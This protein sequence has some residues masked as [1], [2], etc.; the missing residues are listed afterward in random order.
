MK[1]ERKA[2]LLNFLRMQAKPLSIAEI[3]HASVIQELFG[4][5]QKTIQ[6]DIKELLSEGKVQSRDNHP[7]RFSAATPIEVTVTLTPS[8]IRELMKSASA[9]VKA[10]LKKA[11]SNPF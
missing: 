8:E 7:A 11:L 2:K 3:H 9:P 6:R 4:R 10:K 5:T 1:T